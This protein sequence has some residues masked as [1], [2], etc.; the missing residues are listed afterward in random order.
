VAE[1]WQ[2]CAAGAGADGDTFVR[3]LR[4]RQARDQQR[5]AGSKEQAA[6]DI[7]CDNQLD[8]YRIHGLFP[9]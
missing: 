7:L 2:P 3:S 5:H 1:Q 4:R 9:G 6:D 8:A